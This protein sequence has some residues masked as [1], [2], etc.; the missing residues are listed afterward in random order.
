MPTNWLEVTRATSAYILAIEL[1]IDNML[2]ADET[3]ITFYY[4]TKML[5]PTGT[6]RVGTSVS[7]ENEKK[8]ITVVVT[9]NLLSSQLPP[10]FIV[11]TG[12]FGADLMKA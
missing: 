5:V 7:V 9:A 10:A 1:K 2:A 8:G 4:S 6:K 11:N 3:F 12:M